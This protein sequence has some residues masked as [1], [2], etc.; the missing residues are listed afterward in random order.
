MGVRKY[1]ELEEYENAS[2]EYL[3]NGAKAE[4]RKIYSNDLGVYF[5]KP[6][7]EGQRKPKI[8]TR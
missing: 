3:W 8:S 6:V 5:T 1:F 4:Q 2:D 7:K